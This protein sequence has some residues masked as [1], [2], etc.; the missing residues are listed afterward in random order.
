MLI[1][2][3]QPVFN[4]LYLFREDHKQVRL[5]RMVNACKGYYSKMNAKKLTFNLK[6]LVNENQEIISTYSQMAAFNEKHM[7]T[8]T[9]LL[10][11]FEI[12]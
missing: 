5:C 1:G 4:L 7:L 6:E 12:L 9:Y 2:N 11:Q 8:A 3:F 10:F